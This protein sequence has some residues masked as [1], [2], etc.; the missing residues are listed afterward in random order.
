MNID[1]D[2]SELYHSR[3]D[4]PDRITQKEILSA[5]GNPN[6]RIFE[7][8]GYPKKQM[9]HLACGYSIS[10]RFLLIVGKF[11]NNRIKILQ[12]KVADESEIESYFCRP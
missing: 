6:C 11:E 7:M 10:K 12:V 2:F 5:Y 4:Y 8:E 1:L 9:F 3:G